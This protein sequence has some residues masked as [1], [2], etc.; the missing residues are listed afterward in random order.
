MWLVLEEAPVS[1]TDG[2]QDQRQFPLEDLEPESRWAKRQSTAHV[3]VHVQPGTSVLFKPFSQDLI[4]HQ[5]GVPSGYLLVVVLPSDGQ[6]EIPSEV[7][8]RECITPW[9]H[10]P[11]S[12][13]LVPEGYMQLPRSQSGHRTAPRDPSRCREA[14][15]GAQ[16]CS[17]SAEV[18]ILSSCRSARAGDERASV[19]PLVDSTGI[20]DCFSVV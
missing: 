10:R 16:A 19:E 3:T 15:H 6:E 9:G 7:G 11:E 1:V 4:P 8:V 12:R 2:L 13:G 20:P 17:L 5:L 14:R 18:V